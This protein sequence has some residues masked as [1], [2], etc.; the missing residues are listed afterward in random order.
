ME[1]RNGIELEENM[2]R[3]S[4]VLIL[5]HRGFPRIPDVK[6]THIPKF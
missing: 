3:Q 4:I 6:T 1:K 5:G 2:I